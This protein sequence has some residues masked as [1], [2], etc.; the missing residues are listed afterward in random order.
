MIRAIL[1]GW[2]IGCI[3]GAFPFARAMRTLTP[4]E[5]AWVHNPRRHP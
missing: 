5:R 2:L 4:E 1:L 3:A